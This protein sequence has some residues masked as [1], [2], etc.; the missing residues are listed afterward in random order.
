[1]PVDLMLVAACVIAMFVVF[2]TVLAWGD[3]QNRPRQ[4]A[5][6]PTPSAWRSDPGIAVE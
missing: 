2:A 5:E 4:S 6:R 3:F 1:M